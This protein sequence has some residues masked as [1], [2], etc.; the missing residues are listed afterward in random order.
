[1]II[2]KI[3]GVEERFS[4]FKG[5]ASEAS[6]CLHANILLVLTAE[7]IRLTGAKVSLEYTHTLGDPAVAA[8]AALIGE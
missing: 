5:P 1:M 3:R 8:A 4:A 2:R 7:G 6:A